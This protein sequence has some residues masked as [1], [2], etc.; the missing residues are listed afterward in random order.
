MS[1]LARGLPSRLCDEDELPKKAVE[2]RA[3]RFRGSTVDMFNPYKPWF[4]DALC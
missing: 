3:A 2:T 4:G 1:D